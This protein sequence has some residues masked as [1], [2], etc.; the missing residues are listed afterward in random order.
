MLSGDSEMAAK[1]LFAVDLDS[2]FLMVTGALDREEQA[3]YK[4]QV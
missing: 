1:G 4:L 2:G 3:E